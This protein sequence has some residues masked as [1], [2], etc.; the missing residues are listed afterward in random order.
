M[1]KRNL[2]KIQSIVVVLFLMSGYFPSAN[3]YTAD[4]TYSTAISVGEA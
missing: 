1:F 2:F 4:F 3:A